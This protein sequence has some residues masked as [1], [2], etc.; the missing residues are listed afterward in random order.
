M[1]K[2]ILLLG[3]ALLSVSLAVKADHSVIY[4]THAHDLHD[5]QARFH[6]NP[7]SGHAWVTLTA[8]RMHDDVPYKNL[9]HVNGLRYDA[10]RG[11]VLLSSASGDLVCGTTRERG[12]GPFRSVSVVP[13]GACQIEANI[14]KRPRDNGFAVRDQRLLEVRLTTSSS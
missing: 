8:N 7:A 5:V 14:V 1:K 2:S 11:Q 12:F 6:V 3:G 4:V 9:V 10:S 13:S